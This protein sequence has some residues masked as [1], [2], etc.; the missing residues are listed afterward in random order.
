MLNIG[1]GGSEEKQIVLHLTEVRFSTVA[2]LDSSW[3]PFFTVMLITGMCSEW[4]CWTSSRETQNSLLKAKGSSFLSVP[5]CSV[6]SATTTHKELAGRGVGTAGAENSRSQ[7]GT[8][9]PLLK[10]IPL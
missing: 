2:D 5:V 1:E 10:S 6:S 3:N 9:C 8:F 7:R 4:A